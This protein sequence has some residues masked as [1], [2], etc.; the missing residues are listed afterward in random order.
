MNNSTD[1]WKILA[2]KF[3]ALLERDEAG[4]K[5]ALTLIRA[6]DPL[7]ADELEKMLQADARNSG[8]LDQQFH[9]H[10]KAFINAATAD[11]QNAT[12]SSLKIGDFVLLRRLGEGGMGEVWLAKRELDGF[13]QQVALKLLKPGMDSAELIRRFARERRI[14]ADLDHP[15]IARFIDGGVGADGRLFYAMEFIDG[16]PITEFAKQHQCSVQQCVE[17][18]LKVTQAA[19]HA[20]NHLVVHRDLKPSNILVDKESNPR[21]LDFGIAKLLETDLAEEQ[22]AS[23]VRA[24]SPA[25]AAPEQI[26]GQAISS[27]TDVY[28]LGVILFEMLTDH[29]PHK[30]GSN[31]HSLASAIET[32]TVEAPSLLLKRAISAAEKNT[33]NRYT[34]SQW[35][36][37]I[38]NDLDVIVTTALAREPHRRYPNATE[39]A[40]D[41][42]RWLAHQPIKAQA[43]TASYRVRKFIARH[44]YMVGSASAVVLAIVAGLALALWQARIANQQAKRANIEAQRARVQATRADRTKDFVLALFREQ[45]PLTRAKTRAMTAGELIELGITQAKN[46]FAQ[47][48][49][50]QAQILNELGEIQ[51][52][53]GDIKPSAATFEAALKLF[54]AT[55]GINSIEYAAV[56]SDLGGVW[57]ALGEKEAAREAIQN[58]TASLAKIAGADHYETAV[59][60]TRL[61]RMFM[62]QSKNQEALE[63]LDHAYAIFAKERGPNHSETLRRL[64]NRGVVLEQLDRLPEAQSTF[65]K[66]IAGYIGQGETQHAQLIYPRTLLADILRR[67]RRYSEAAE[68]YQAALASAETALE[69]NHPL[70]GQIAFRMGDLLRRQRRFNEAEL[71]WQKAEAILKPLGSPELGQIEVYRGQSALLQEKYSEAITHYQRG[72]AHY[73]KTLGPDTIYSRAAELSLAKVRAISGDSIVALRDA[74]SAYQAMQKIALPDSF[75]LAFAMESY[76]EVLLQLQRWEEARKHLQAALSINQKMYGSE[77]GSVTSL[78]VAIAQTLVGQKHDYATAQ[79]LLDH[80][81]GSIK[82]ADPHDPILGDAMLARGKA[83]LGLKNSQGAR[84]DWQSAK[85]FLT[86]EYGASDKRVKEILDLLSSTKI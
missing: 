67:Q 75:D 17:L 11:G 20:Q 37:Q 48:P 55:S 25:Y 26:L 14:L 61:A 81:I 70:I 23:H 16:I 34:N 49:H 6:T 8:I 41:L 56:Q 27:A 32:E 59:A 42:R 3:D 53:L 77:H 52:S 15:N 64:Y 82:K 38:D 68:M 13:A 66:V 30:R 79:T 45:D 54:A 24:L 76:A 9:H 36:R 86:K 10:A 7:L 78:E 60:Q 80:A 69:S 73:R 58:S 43:D 28:A 1:Q 71:A 65:E 21:L 74:E 29:R 85:V 47:D 57:L 44:R 40:D 72:L 31:L 33:Q 63:L 84:D 12:R 18:I 39:M 83:R 5:Q 51:F 62:E 35:R 4:R 19:A 22:T 46:D 50:T 2:E